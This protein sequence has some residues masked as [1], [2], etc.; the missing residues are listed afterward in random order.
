MSQKCRGCGFYTL[1][2]QCKKD[3]NLCGG[4]KRVISDCRCGDEHK[5]HNRYPY[6]TQKDD[7]EDEKDAPCNRS[8]SSGGDNNS[9]DGG[10]NSGDGGNNRCD[11]GDD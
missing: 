2:C 5:Y 4:C 6:T 8:Y 9:Y 1:A 3:D 11:G 7:Y 10:N